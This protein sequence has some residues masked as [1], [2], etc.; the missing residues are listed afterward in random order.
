VRRYTAAHE[1]GHH[2]LG[3]EP[4]ADDEDMIKRSPFKGSYDPQEAEAD[5]FAIA[6]LVPLWFVSGTM[7]QRSWKKADMA[8]PA[9]VY[10]LALR[11]GASYE[12]TCYALRNHRVVDS[13][14]CSNLTRVQPKE[15]KQSIVTNFTPNNWRL[16]VWS[17]DERDRGVFLEVAPN[18]VLDVS[19]DEHSGGGYMWDVAGISQTDF[20]LVGDRR[21]RAA[22]V[23][24][25]GAH[26]QRRLTAQAKTVGVGSVQFVE[27]RPWERG[28][29]PLNSF[30]F[31]YDVREIEKPGLLNV[32][33][34]RMV[35]GA[36]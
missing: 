27:R 15:I 23:N 33:L 30:Q 16:D 10:Q 17:L 11:A 19:L 26:A 25:V 14:T 31:T 5:A 21:E 34:E 20:E 7:Q 2:R 12:A 36:G 3:H 6:F 29:S 24:A 9:N 22:A 32:Q 1:L 13:G 35:G 4:S 28:A 18:D 8:T